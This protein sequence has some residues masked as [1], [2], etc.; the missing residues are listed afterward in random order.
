MIQIATI[1]GTKHQGNLEFEKIRMILSQISSSEAPVIFIALK[2]MHIGKIIA[3]W[4]VFP[5]GDHNRIKG[6]NWNI[7]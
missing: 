4:R 3:I 7:S 2:R 6:K 1:N 5:T